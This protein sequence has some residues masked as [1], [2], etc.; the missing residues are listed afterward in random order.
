MRE[1]EID[2]KLNGLDEFI[3]ETIKDWKIPG[4]AIG[5][6]KED[7]V[8]Y[9]KGFGM[10]DPEKDLE[11]N[12]E[13]LFLTAS[14]TKAFTS[15]SIGI[16]VDEGKLEWDKPIKHYI[17]TFKLFD[18]YATEHLTLRDILC[19]RSGLP[20]HDWSMDDKNLTRKDRVELLQYLEPNMDIRAKHQYNNI[21]FMLAGYVVECVT[22]E[23]WEKFV[24]ERILD[25]LEMTSTNFS[26]Y[27]S[28]K[29][30]NFAEHY[31]EVNDEIKKFT[32]ENNGDP[33][34]F[35][36]RGPAGSINSNIIDLAKWLKL[37]L[38]KG[39]YNGKRIISE[40]SLK[41]MHLPQIVDFW[42]I[43]DKEYSD[44]SCGMGWFIWY[45]RGHKIVEHGG[46]FGTRIL[47]LPNERIGII[48]L[49]TLLSLAQ[50]SIPN[51]IIDRL[52]GYEATP[53][54]ERKKA[55]F[56][57]EKEKAKLEAEKIKAQFPRKEGTK[58]SHELKD[59]VGVYNHP[60]Y[61]KLNIGLE[62]EKLVI[63]HWGEK[64]TLSHYH[65]DTFEVLDPSGE[66]IFRLTF[67]TDAN[68]LVN[69]ITSPFEPTIKDIEFLRI[70]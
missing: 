24:Q 64:F 23:I 65:Y 5:V 63:S 7:E 68:G 53:W 18:P 55:L 26:R 28:M 35:S 58:P 11:V 52:L 27:K 61:L 3:M 33:D 14:N 37:H 12:A 4:L 30:D 66:L 6:V 45:Y 15:M 20:S 29:T 57:E 16:L 43:R 59:Y 40:E 2:N 34:S 48:Y 60:A 9:S 54:N 13:T 42:D 21:M 47:L 10:R 39:V 32:W 36:P 1:K 56:A 19:H 69:S 41:Q 51:T 67:H 22:G 38:N 49:P 70:K 62:D 50:D 17:P 8:I 44:G 25:P 31:H 46:F